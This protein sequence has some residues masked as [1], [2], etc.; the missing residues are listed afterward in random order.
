V[1]KGKCYRNFA[2]YGLIRLNIFVSSFSPHLCNLFLI[3]LYLILLISIQTSDVTRAKILPFALLPF[4][5]GS[6]Q[7]LISTAV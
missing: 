7:A 3:K 5:L 6:K 2:N 4:A 1:Q